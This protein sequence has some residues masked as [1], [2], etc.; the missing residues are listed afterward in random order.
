LTA[1]QY[2]FVNLYAMAK[3]LITG[4]GGQLGQCLLDG[5]LLRPKQQVLGYD[6]DHLDIADREAVYFLAKESG[7]SV[8]INGAAYTSVDQAEE[9][10]AQAWAVNANAVQGLA[11]VCDRL[12]ILL[13]HISTDYVFDGASSIPY[14]EEDVPHPLSVYGASKLAGEGFAFACKKSVVVR[15]S[16]LYSHSGHNFISSILRLGAERDEIRVVHD[17]VSAP[18]FA[19]HLAA[20]LFRMIE[21]M[22]REEWSLER[23]GLY[24]F[25]NSGY[26]S[27]YTFAQ[28]IK[29]W[30]RFKALVLPIA[31]SEFEALAQR[32]A[33]SVLDT[34][35]IR[36]SFGVNPPSWEEGLK[37]Y[38]TLK[39]I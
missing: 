1:Y 13:V 2:L 11:E 37:D 6:L 12:G 39:K 33:C 16:W 5:A 32:P 18:T 31:S 27:R 8:L 23:M 4:A 21:Q 24:H 25:C 22:E 3:I 15:T 10:P 26:C 29:E 19:P 36:T 9:E 28:K 7:A 30:S 38:F 17:Q 34:Q 20:A 14:T 35:K